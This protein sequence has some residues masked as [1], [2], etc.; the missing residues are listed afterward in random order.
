MACRHSPATRLTATRRGIYRRL[1]PSILAGAVM[2]QDRVE[3]D[4]LLPAEGNA[5]RL[6]GLTPG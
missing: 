2:G 1:A 3:H 6:R 5:F 4:G